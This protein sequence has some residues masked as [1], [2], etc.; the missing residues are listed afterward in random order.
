[1]RGSAR[2]TELES[3]AATGRRGSRVDEPAAYQAEGVLYLPPNTRF[4]YLLSLPEGGEIGKAVNDAMREIEKHNDSLAGVLPKTYERFTSGLIKQ[5]L[6][7]VSE[8]P[9]T[10]GYDAFAQDL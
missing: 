7:K 10:T 2:R 3:A 6:K 5:L 4:D 1:M 9:A 8:I